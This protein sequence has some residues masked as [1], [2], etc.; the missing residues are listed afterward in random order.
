MKKLSILKIYT[1]KIIVICEKIFDSSN[2]RDKEEK[3]TQDHNV[4]LCG[5]E[6]KDQTALFNAVI[7][8]SMSSFV[9]SK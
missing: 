9:M 6:V 1:T 5:G 8:I 3:P 4:I 2:E 7:K